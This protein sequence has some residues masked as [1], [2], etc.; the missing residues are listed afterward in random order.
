MA[1]KH[2]FFCSKITDTSEIKTS[3]QVKT[4]AWGP[5]YIKRKKY[6]DKAQGISRLNFFTAESVWIHSTKF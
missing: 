3:T 1:N 4:M 2:R 6:L 5:E